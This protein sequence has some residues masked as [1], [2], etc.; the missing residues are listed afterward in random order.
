MTQDVIHHDFE[1]DDG[2][3]SRDFDRLAE[4]IVLNQPEQAFEQLQAMFP[5]EFAL[6]SF[7]SEQRKYRTLKGL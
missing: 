3:T 7:T 5:R 4:H 2:L 6:T 1:Y